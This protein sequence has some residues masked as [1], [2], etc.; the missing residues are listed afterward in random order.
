MGKTSGEAI[1][2]FNSLPQDEFS[3]VTG[4][5]GTLLELAK[6]G[7]GVT[8]VFPSSLILRSHALIQQNLGYGLTYAGAQLKL[9]IRDSIST[10][11][12]A[13]VVDDGKSRFAYEN[14][15]EK[16][17]EVT[18]F[19]GFP[20]IRKL[21]GQEYHFPVHL[22]QLKLD[23]AKPGIRNLRTP[24]KLTE[25]I[26]QVRLWQYLSDELN[27]MPIILLPHFGTRTD[28]FCKKRKP[29]VS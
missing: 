14:Y 13:A 9:R 5:F 16:Q 27:W 18:P 22:S 25:P 24:F 12:L 6:Q 20:S 29:C 8:L 21:V 7:I 26:R 28:I 3:I 19:D 23:S 10:Y 17:Q 11:K 4:K 15:L 1:F 2:Y